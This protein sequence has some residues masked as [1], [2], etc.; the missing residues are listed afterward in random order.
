[1]IKRL[2]DFLISFIGLVL[3]APILIGTY[4]LVSKKLGT[5]VLFKQTR[6]GKHAKPFEIYKF[7]TMTDD[8]DVNGDLLPDE[9]RMT[10]LG[11][12]IRSASIDELPQLINVLKGDLS[13]VGPRPLLMEY[14]PL[15]SDEQKKRHNVKPGITGWAQ[16]NGRNAISWD[17]KFKLDVLYVENQSFQLDMYILYKTIKNVLRKKDVSAQS[18]VTTEKFKGNA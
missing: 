9:N 4:F 5:P 11:S 1:M 15:Y 10:K 16:V 14:L 12:N 18:H 2:F 7:R 13:L 3:T 8:K 17:Q 6:P